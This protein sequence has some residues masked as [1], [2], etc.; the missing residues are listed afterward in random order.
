VTIYGSWFSLTLLHDRLPLP[1]LAVLGGIILAWHGSLQHESIHGHPSGPRWL[2]W[3]LGAPP[4]SLWLPYGIYRETHRRH[5]ATHRLTDP[6]HDP[7]APFDL[8]TIVGV[9]G[10]L[11]RAIEATQRT[12]LGRLLFGPLLMV[13]T[14][15]GTELLAI[16]RRTPGHRRAWA[17]HA[18]SVAIVLAWL[19]AVADVPLWKYFL[20][21]VYPG[22]S[23]TL[24]RSFAEHRADTIPERRTTVVEAGF[25]FSL[26]FLNNNLHVVHHAAPRVPWFELPRLWAHERPSFATRAPDLIHAGYVS[27][28][29]K[30]ALQ[31][32]EGG[33]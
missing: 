7:E 22:A 3:A 13:G 32:R 27:I 15:L 24:L 8:G 12:A 25:F 11:V 20:A 1:L 29:R 26:I 30:W 9:R 31:P 33:R 23:L 5:H 17:L 4:L 6:A 10:S 19:I 2:G 16:V 14:F 18:V 21:F 28:I